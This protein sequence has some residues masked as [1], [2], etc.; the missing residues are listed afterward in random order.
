MKKNNIFDLKQYILPIYLAVF[1]LIFADFS[2]GSWMFVLIPL[3]IISLGLFYP[4]KYIGL[5]G[6]S[7]FLVISLSL[8]NISSIENI[9]FIILLIV[10]IIFPSIL[11]LCQILQ[12]STI[13][14]TIQNIMYPYK[15]LVTSLFLVFCFMSIIYLISF[16]VG[17]GILFSSDLVQEKII[18]IIGIS[19]IFFGLFLFKKSR[20]EIRKNSLE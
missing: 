2:V 15:A 12:E 7:L 5:L 9:I 3:F 14:E 17:D 6:F 20:Y 13:Q 19:I 16:F 11:L 8:I 18:L 4:K 1:L 10:L